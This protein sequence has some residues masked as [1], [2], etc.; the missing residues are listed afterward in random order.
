MRASTRAAAAF[1]ALALALTACG[2]DGDDGDDAGTED[3]GTEDTGTEDAGAEDGGDGGVSADDLDLVSQD[4]LTVCSD[5]PYPPFEFE[6]PDAPS[7]YSGF[8]VDIMQAVADR[9][10]VELAVR[11]TLF[12]NIENGTALGAGECDVAASAMTITDDRREVMDFS[13]P[14]YDSVQSLLV[15]TGS[16][17]D[18]LESL[19]GQRIG[20]QDGTTGKDYAEENAPDDAEI[21]QFVSAG[22][23][24]A[25]LISGGV[26]ALL[27]DLPVNAERARE[28]DA[29][30]VS[31]EF[32]TGEQY[33]FA[34]AADRDDGLLELVDDEL[35]VMR[36]DGRYDE[37][38]DQYFGTE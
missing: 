21:V 5:V 37:L 9:L 25:A 29:L 14:Y 35:A 22:D 20:V 23:M 10:D 7:G 17:Y 3:T 34:V 30:E 6:D 27:Q 36:D 15:A 38:Y 26:E 18:S 2:D 13:E 28:D 16:G 1:A 11:A 4:E 12:D 8:D 19:S 33:G 32:D 24:F 31:A